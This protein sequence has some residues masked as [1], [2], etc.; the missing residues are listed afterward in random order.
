M[1]K[2][3]TVLNTTLEELGHP[4]PPTPLQSDNTISTGYINGTIK[5]KGTRSMDMHFYWVK[6][7][8]KKGNFMS[9]G[10]QDTKIKRIISQNTIRRLIIKE[11]EKYTYT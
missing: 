6:Y 5:Q 4:Q 7:R 10:A 1:Q 8:A 2:K 3:R 9:F 11:C